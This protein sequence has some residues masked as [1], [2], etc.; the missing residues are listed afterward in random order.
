MYNAAAKYVGAGL[1]IF[2]L[3][4]SVE[5]P[6]HLPIIT[7]LGSSFLIDLRTLTYEMEKLNFIHKKFHQ[8]MKSLYLFV[9]NV[10]TIKSY[11][12]FHGKQ[13]YSLEYVTVN[14]I[15]YYPVP[16]MVPGVRKL[17]HVDSL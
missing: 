9:S 13:S 7:S 2:A 15:S 4:L 11:W 3:E 1:F 6:L 8:P 10:F 14:N 12:W 17:F 5:L 16:I